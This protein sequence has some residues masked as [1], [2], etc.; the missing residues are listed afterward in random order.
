MENLSETLSLIS[1]IDHIDREIRKKGV[2]VFWVVDDSR[3][4]IGQ[5]LAD[6]RRDIGSAIMLMESFGYRIPVLGVVKRGKSSLVNYMAGADLSPVNALPET[7]SLMVIGNRATADLGSIGI[8]WNGKVEKLSVKAEKFCE[9]VR[10]TD[11]DPFIVARFVGQCE[12]AENVWLIDTPGSSEANLDTRRKESDG[13]PDALYA[14]ATSF[15]V[16]LGVPGVSSCD[17]E[18]LSEVKERSGG[19]P[20]FVVLKALDS[21]VPMNVLEDFRQEY[22]AS[23]GIKVFLSSDKDLTQIDELRSVIGSSGYMT[24]D[25]AITVSEKVIYES[26]SKIKNLLQQLSNVGGIEIPKVLLSTLSQSVSDYAHDQLPEVIAKNKAETLRIERERLYK[27]YLAEF[28]KWNQRKQ[29]KLDEI[30]RYRSEL[31]RAEY[32]LKK[33]GPSS[34]C[35]LGILFAISCLFFLIP[36]IPIAVGVLCAFARNKE[37]KL[38]SVNRPRLE[39]SVSRARNLLKAAEKEQEAINL[40]EPTRVSPK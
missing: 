15:I 31:A 19:K 8:N 27:V 9:Q 22:L 24:S 35:G 33:N 37:I 13:I 14:L 26:E 17:L 6:L 20:I 25:E 36:L 30:K 10:R 38:A 2:Q 18:L 23:L 3:V 5:E 29:A 21:S 28:H 7:A 39:A 1:L 12:L 4:S 34:G 11:S 16:V 32:D 40:S